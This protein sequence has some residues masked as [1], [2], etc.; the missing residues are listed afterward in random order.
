M[1]KARVLTCENGR[2]V[3]IV[4]VVAEPTHVPVPRTVT[5]IQVQNVTA[6]VRVPKDRAVKVDEPSVPVHLLL[7]RLGDEMLV[8]PQ[9]VEDVGVQ[10]D[11]ARLLQ[12]PELLL[13]LHVR[14]AAL[15]HRHLLNLGEVQF[16]ERRGTSVRLVRNDA[17][18]LSDELG[19]IEATTFDGD[20]LR[21]ADE[22]L[23]AVLE[24]RR[25]LSASFLRV[26]NDEILKPRVREVN[27][28]PVSIHSQSGKNLMGL[29]D[30]DLSHCLSP[31][32]L[33]GSFVRRFAI[34]EKG[35]YIKPLSAVANA[36]YNSKNLSS[37]IH[38]N[39]VFVNISRSAVFI[40]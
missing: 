6:T 26:A 30:G 5:P 17:P 7:P 33:E 21:F 37:T 39:A 15:E 8:L 16:G 32:V 9:R 1:T 22:D 27:R 40:H 4:P 29:V 20:D 36:S 25:E 34:A 31:C 2:R 23:P 13:A 11:V 10:S 19:W 3:V 14:L 12:T 18:A 28:C 35:L 38:L 24:E